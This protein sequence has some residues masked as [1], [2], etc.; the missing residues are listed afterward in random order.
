MTTEESPRPLES[1][2]DENREIVALLREGDD[3]VRIE[4]LET[5]GEVDD[6]LAEEL[7]RIL[8]SDA[9]EEIR[10]AAAISLGPT[11]EIVGTD[12]SDDGRV[13]EFFGDS[14][15]SQQV[16]D[17]VVETFKRVCLDEG[18]PTLVRRRV[19][20]AAVR[21]PKRWQEGVIRSAWAGDDPDWRLTAVFAM[22]YVT[23]VDHTSEIEAAFGSD[24]Q[25]LQ[26]EAIRAG[27]LRGV[28]SLL[29]EVTAI[30]ADESARPELRYAAVEAL[31]YLGDEETLELLTD[32]TESD[33]ELL[34]ALAA[35]ALQLAMVDFEDLELDEE[36]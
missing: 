7:L 33:D 14:P 17:R 36:E 11:L 24:S 9:S 28:E 22:G 8:Q 26:L 2:S 3:E 12:L 13:G 31:G 34:A 25:E 23:R 20:E 35:E 32:L 21:S 27:G 29:P 6:E 10:A 1:F 5:F 16:Y 18:Q 30:A 19:F 4:A 15:L